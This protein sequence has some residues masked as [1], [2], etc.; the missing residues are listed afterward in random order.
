MHIRFLDLIE[1]LKQKI[2]ISNNDVKP[3]TVLAITFDSKNKESGDG[4]I[5]YNTENGGLVAIDINKDGFITC[6]EVY[7]ENST[8]IPITEDKEKPPIHL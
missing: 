3:C 5:I 6:I 8:W 2:A 4:E 7:A 1:I